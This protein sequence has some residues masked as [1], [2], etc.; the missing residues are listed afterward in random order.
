MLN[1][2]PAANRAVLA[3]KPQS[4][5]LGALSSMTFGDWLLLGGGVV[6][7][8]AGI[9]NLVANFTGPRPKPNAISVMANLVL[10]AV[11]LTLFIDKGGKAI[12]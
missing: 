9:N 12:A 10:A 6:V 2:A 1:Y 11:G 5:A 3:A 4:P 7:G 8:G